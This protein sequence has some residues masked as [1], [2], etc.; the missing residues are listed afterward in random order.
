MSESQPKVDG[1]TFPEIRLDDMITMVRTLHPEGDAL[2]RLSDA[3][4]LSERL[5]EVAD[6][7]VGHFVDQARKA[8]ATWTDIGQ[9]MGVSKQ[10]AQK[11]F[12]PRDDLFERGPMTRLTIKAREVVLGAREEARANGDSQVGTEHLVLGQLREPAGIGA[13]AL[14][15]Q[16]VTEEQIRAAIKVV[17]PAKDHATDDEPPYSPGA[18][19]ALELSVRE[20]LRMVHNYIGT[21]HILL[22]ILAEEDSLGARV[23]V[24]LGVTRERTDQLI[25]QMLSEL[26]EQRRARPAE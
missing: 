11:R 8:G 20:A 25:A 26:I 9:S 4:L 13:R 7:V 5:G 19:K 10:A 18:R 6:H 24:G 12:V 15:A 17:N 16:G 1:M 21:E 2:A 14:F 23:L 22:G 3:V